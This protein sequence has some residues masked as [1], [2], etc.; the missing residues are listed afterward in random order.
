MF[1][2]ITDKS[3]FKN[4]L[5][6]GFTLVFLFVVWLKWLSLYTNHNDFIRVP[7]FNGVHIGDLD[8]LVGF[9]DLRYQI[10]DSVSII[11]TLFHIL[12]H[13]IQFY[14]DFP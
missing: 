10:I 5:F 3:L 2:F 4:L 7:D 1:K 9:C 6:A 11:E 14:T 8:S 13:M 12:N